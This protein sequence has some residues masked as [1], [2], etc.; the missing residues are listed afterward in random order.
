M[1]QPSDPGSVPAAG[2][3]PPQQGWS[4]VHYGP[5]IRG[6]DLHTAPPHGATP[7]VGQ[8]QVGQSPFG[9]PSV[10]Q[11][12]PLA[13]PWISTGAAQPPATTSQGWGQPAGLVQVGLV[14]AGPAVGG[15]AVWKRRVA[16][17]LIDF[18]P[19][20]LVTVAAYVV[21]GM[22][23]IQM[24]R[25]RTTGSLDAQL[26]WAVPVGIVLAIA[27]LG[28]LAWQLYNRWIVA[29][30]TGQS[31]GKRVLRLRLISEQTGQPIG[32]LNAFLRDLM[33]ILDGAA[34]LGFLWPLWDRRRQTFSDKLMR[35]LVV[36]LPEQTP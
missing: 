15:P 24:L 10:G 31:W 32:T 36:D 27:A 18:W 12:Q 6:S 11:S 2:S 14:Q 4:G 13:T 16:A 28:A 29:G 23:M 7:Q 5:V 1:S 30:R 22:V 9:P 8:S 20:V 3:P 25:Q 19:S 33:H 21:Y 34:Y 17:Y 26:R 35:T